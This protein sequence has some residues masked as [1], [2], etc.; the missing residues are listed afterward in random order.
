M[1]GAKSLIIKKH[2]IVETTTPQET[3]QKICAFINEQPEVFAS[4]G[5]AAF[6][7][8]CLDRTSPNYGSVTTTP[9]LAWQHAP[10]LKMVLEGIDASKK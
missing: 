6:G 5:I 2:K 10:L 9:K 3:I 7:P 1:E 4:L 8:L